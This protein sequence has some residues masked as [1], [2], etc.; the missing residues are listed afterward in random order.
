MKNTIYILSF[1]ISTTILS[2]NNNGEIIYLDFYNKKTSKENAFYYVNKSKYQNNI[3]LY[4][5]YARSKQDTIIL[6]EK[7]FYDEKGNKQGKYI[8]YYIDGKNKS[9]GFYDN[10]LKIGQWKFYK[11]TRRTHKDT[12]N[13]NIYYYKL[14]TYNN[15]VKDGIFKEFYSDGKLRG[16]GN[17]KNNHLFGEC[18]WYFE[19]GQLSSDESYNE[20]G[21]LKEI[22]QWNENGSVY[23]GKMKP[24]KGAISNKKFFAK[25]MSTRIM[26][27]FNKN[28][29]KMYPNKRG[30]IY[31]IFTVNK[32]GIIEKVKTKTNLPMAYSNE[33]KKL[34]LNFPIQK[35]SYYIINLLVLSLL[36]LFQ[37]HSNVKK[38]TTKK[39]L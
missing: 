6:V 24:L 26:N 15:D 21:K 20:K 14:E 10:D 25:K 35:P 27:R 9:L 33:V 11:K 22:K 5:K 3:L 18:K 38:H 17:Y 34:L 23:K 28:I 36:F 8:S 31:A 37:L 4:Q 16:E 32:E 2:Q 7:Y 1:L 13:T 12:L 39:R 19:N 29:F 30:K